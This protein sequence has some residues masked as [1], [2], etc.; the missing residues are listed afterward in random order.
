M[1]LIENSYLRASV[2]CMYNEEV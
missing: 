2:Y 1:W